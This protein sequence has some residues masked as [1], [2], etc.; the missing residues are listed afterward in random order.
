MSKLIDYKRIVISILIVSISFLLAGVIA[1]L[2]S[3][4]GALDKRI[5]TQSL[6]KEC[7]D[8]TLREYREGEAPEKCATEVYGDQF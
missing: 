5:N 6:E 2:N 1:N 8:Y 3:R 4:V 7:L